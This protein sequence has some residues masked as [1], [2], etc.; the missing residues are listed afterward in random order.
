[1][2]VFYLK[3]AE[4]VEIEKCNSEWRSQNTENAAMLL[5]NKQQIDRYNN[6]KSLK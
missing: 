2:E 6:K 3:I 5:R 4:L 1:M